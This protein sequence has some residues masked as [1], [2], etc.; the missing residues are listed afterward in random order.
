M[1]WKK[2]S[3]VSLLLLPFFALFANHCGN[4]H[5][6]GCG[7]VPSVV[8]AI[9]MLPAMYAFLLMGSPISSDTLFWAVFLIVSFAWLT[10]VIYLSSRVLAAIRRRFA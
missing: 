4:V 2:A 8:A 3:A 6:G 1:S 5:G 9:A 10:P 7:M